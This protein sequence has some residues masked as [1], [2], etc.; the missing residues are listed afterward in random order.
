MDTNS[1]L[2][3]FWQCS[4]GIALLALTALFIYLCATLGSLR[5]SL[6]SIQNTLNSTENLVNQEL[7]ILISDVSHTVKEINK[8]LPQLLQN[9]NGVTASLQKISEDEI[10]PTLHNVQEM[11][12]KLSQSVQELESLVQMVANFSGQTIEQAEYFRNHVAVSLADII[13]MWHGLKAGW[14]RLYKSSNSNE[15][16]ESNTVNN[17][18]Q[19]HVQDNASETETAPEKPEAVAE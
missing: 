15:V 3:I 8:E 13:G 19:P 18:S 9:I 11:T 4:L 1:I 5:N 10:Q 14:D 6:N 7:G 12:E 17:E 16:Y 2:S